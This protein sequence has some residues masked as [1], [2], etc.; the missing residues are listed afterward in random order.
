VCLESIF[1]YDFCPFFSRKSLVLPI[2]L[3]KMSGFVYTFAENKGF[4]W[5]FCRK[6]GVLPVVLQ[7]TGGLAYIL[8]TFAENLPTLAFGL[9]PKF[10]IGQTAITNVS[11][12]NKDALHIKLT[13]IFSLIW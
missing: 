4:C 12:I 8:A 5:C 2:L 11:C 9:L 7:K 6:V 3:P 1:R 10:Q 13:A